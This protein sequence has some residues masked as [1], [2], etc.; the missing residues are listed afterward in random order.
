[1]GRLLLAL[2]IAGCTAATPYNDARNRI[3]SHRRLFIAAWEREDL[4]G[5]KDA[6]DKSRLAY[7]EIIGESP[8]YDRYADNLFSL[9]AAHIEFKEFQRQ[10]LLLDR[11]SFQ[12]H[13]DRLNEAIRIS[14]SEVE[15]EL[16]E[17]Q[18]RAN[19][20]TENV[21]GFL[22]ILGIVGA[23]VLGAA[24]TAPRTPPPTIQPIQP[25]VNTHCYQSGNN[26]YCRSY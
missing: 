3:E 10:G 4:A 2:L 12:D 26:V 23:G 8:A 5:A 21:N 17:A 1:M 20:R 7:K 24:A 13:F 22:S 9:A 15:A 11:K 14:R 16:R 6:L 18:F 25:P 19:S